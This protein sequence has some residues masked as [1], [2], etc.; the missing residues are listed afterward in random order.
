MLP[1]G[2]RREVQHR[3]DSYKKSYGEKEGM[4]QALAVY[5]SGPGEFKNIKT[6][7]VRRKGEIKDVRE[8]GQVTNEE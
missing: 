7:L 8:R 5:G 2:E 3:G 1:A 6:E 4:H